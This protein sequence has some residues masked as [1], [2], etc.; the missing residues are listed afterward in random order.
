MEFILL[1]AIIGTVYYLRGI[2]DRL[3]RVE[4]ALRE[5][6][7]VEPLVRHS[8]AAGHADAST[9][10]QSAAV[11][12]NATPDLQPQTS[13]AP[14][15]FERPVSD[16][17]PTQWVGGIGALAL[18]FGLAF[19]F[20]YAID[21]G[22]IT[23][24]MRILL[25][26]A[27]GSLLVALGE[28]WKKKYAQYAQVLTGGG[29]A[30][31]YFS[32]F[33]SYQFYHKVEQPIAFLCMVLVTVLGVVLSY[34]YNAKA[35]AL[36]AVVGGYITPILISSGENKQISL[37]A[38][39]TVL[40]VG[41]LLMLLR[42]Y[43]VELLFVAL[44]GTGL[45]FALW[46]M[47]YSDTSNIPVSVAFLVFNYLLVGI[48]T[49]AIFR[50]L[51]E[52]KQLPANTDIHLGIFYAIFGFA[53]FGTVMG[54]LNGHFHAYLAPVM[55]LLSVVTFLS[56]VVIDRLDYHKLNY[57]LSFIGSKFLVFA[58]LFQFK[59]FTAD[60][61]LL[62][63]A[64][65]GLGVGFLVNRK[66]LRTWGLVVFLLSG[67]K[68]AFSSVADAEY[69]FLFNPRFALEVIWIIGLLVLAWG[70]ER[71]LIESDERDIPDVLRGLAA[72][73][74]WWSG[75][76]ELVQQFD[77]PENQNV[78]NLM[79]SVWWML[80]AVVL[81]IVG[82]LQRESVFRKAAVLLF[83]ITVIKVFLYDVQA[84]ELAYRIV[85]FILLG[86]ILMSVAFAYQKNKDKLQKF[87]GEAPKADPQENHTI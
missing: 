12:I 56:Y 73:L 9:A 82:S 75:S 10:Q 39:L 84:L 34:R 57:P 3:R 55:V 49:A 30:I 36:L 77:S 63:A 17:N 66:D 46:G 2:S 70:Y 61:Y 68:V 14:A 28:L 54:L 53:M 4:I 59:G 6:A 20:K 79:L 19:F 65:L 52:D 42:Q 21:Q 37:F 5:R 80:F 72:T 43:W 35:L 33:A 23:E 41:V 18:L 26:V 27:V 71:G 8:P 15:A 48:I 31:L 69:V 50:K 58:I 86:V 25:G 29:I 44:F 11:L 45:D 13:S 62:V 81:A 1:V 87:L 40:N 85:S 47:S 24:W 60:M 16:I 74:M 78:R 38:Y 7:T 32:I 76:Q 22:W 83:G 51:H 67:V 64:A